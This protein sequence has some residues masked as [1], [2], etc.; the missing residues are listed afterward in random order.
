MGITD[1]FRGKTVDVVNKLVA[2]FCSDPDPP[3][4]TDAPEEVNGSFNIVVMCDDMACCGKTFPGWHPCFTV[5]LV[6]W[7]TLIHPHEE[8]HYEFGLLEEEAG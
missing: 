6:R 5:F 3:I 2:Q 1:F 8:T 4:C 7:G